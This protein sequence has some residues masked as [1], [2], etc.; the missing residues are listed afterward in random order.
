MY[1]SIFRG[2]MRLVFISSSVRCRTRTRAAK[3]PQVWMSRPPANDQFS[4][5]VCLKQ[6]ITFSGFR[7]GALDSATSASV[8]IFFHLV[9]AAH[10]QKYFD[11]DEVVSSTDGE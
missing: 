7:P 5:C 8:R 9:A 11:Q 1:S 4:H 6:T 10:G 2:G 3:W